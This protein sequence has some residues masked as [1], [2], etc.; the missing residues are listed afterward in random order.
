MRSLLQRRAGTICTDAGSARSTIAR[1]ADSR[2]ERDSGPAHAPSRAQP[3]AKSSPVIAVPRQSV[4][5]L[6]SDETRGTAARITRLAKSA[7]EFA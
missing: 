6:T 5:N 4:L 2:H 3:S 7:K 1:D